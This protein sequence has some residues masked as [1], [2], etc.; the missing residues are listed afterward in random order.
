ML[1]KRTQ[2]RKDARIIVKYTTDSDSSRL[3]SASFSRNISMGGFCLVV[4]DKLSV[5]INISLR[6]NLSAGN[7]DHDYMKANAR[8]IWIKEIYED[9]KYQI[10]VKFTEID[11][12]L[13]K[14]IENWRVQKE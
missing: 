12:D 7:K 3:F 1:E 2:N 4:S 13:L 5:G 14:R 6:F 10:G 11:K 9:K 8:V